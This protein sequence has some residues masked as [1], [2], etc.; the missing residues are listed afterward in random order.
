MP[1]DFMGIVVLPIFAPVFSPPYPLSN[2]GPGLTLGLLRGLE[3]RPVE[4][5][6]TLRDLFPGDIFF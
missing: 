5:P 6:L 3:D 4:A 2:R 1:Q